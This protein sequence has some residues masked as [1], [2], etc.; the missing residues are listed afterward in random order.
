MSA[1][2]GQFECVSPRQKGMYFEVMRIRPTRMRPAIVSAGRTHGS[3]PT[4]EPLGIWQKIQADSRPDG[5]SANSPQFFVGHGLGKPHEM[6][7][8]AFILQVF[9]RQG[10]GPDIPGQFLPAIPE[11]P[12]CCRRRGR[13]PEADL[14]GLC[15][16]RAD[17]S[18]CRSGRFWS[19]VL[20]RRTAEVT[21]RASRPGANRCRQRECPR[22]AQ[23]RTSGSCS[24]PDRQSGPD[25]PYPG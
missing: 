18:Q 5:G 23:S 19:S 7:Q 10:L 22:P 14:A 25:L 12:L 20:P 4:E 21:Q 15:R 24:A 1:R 11:C 16:R 8:H 2:G 3:A 6:P 17:P 13:A 9:F